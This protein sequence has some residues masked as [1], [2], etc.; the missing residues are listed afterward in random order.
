MIVSATFID[1]FRSN[2]AHKF[3]FQIVGRY[4]TQRLFF[5][6]IC[7][8]FVSN[9]IVFLK[10]E[11]L[12]FI[13]VDTLRWSRSFKI[14]L[15][16]KFLNDIL[17]LWIYAWFGLRLRKKNGPIS[18]YH[19]HSADYYNF[20]LCSLCVTTVKLVYKRLCL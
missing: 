20:N 1:R 19:S 6:E 11:N 5:F 7:F 8:F 4:F 12:P 3:F 18:P 13:G 14:F 17:W 10:F 2:F 15:F 16:S 9:S